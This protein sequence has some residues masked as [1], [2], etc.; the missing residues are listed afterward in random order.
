[1]HN[2]THIYLAAPYRGT[3]EQIEERMKLVAKVSGLIRLEGFYV[4]TPLFHHWAFQ[5][6][7]NWDG[8]YW[9]NYSENLLTTMILSRAFGTKVE[10]WILCTDKWDESEGVSLEK[11]IATK[12]GV[13]VRYIHPQRAELGEI[14]DMNDDSGWVFGGK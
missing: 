1:M 14:F 13:T 10:L 3:P 8:Q 5:E 12:Y 6:E 9:L 4:T 7:D 11:S 2:E